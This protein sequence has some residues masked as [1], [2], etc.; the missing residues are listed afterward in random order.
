MDIFMPV[1]SKLQDFYTSQRAYDENGKFL[2]LWRIVFSRYLF[3]YRV[4][5]IIYYNYFKLYPCHPLK[6]DF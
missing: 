6:S 2:I 4:D 1:L 5:N 3:F